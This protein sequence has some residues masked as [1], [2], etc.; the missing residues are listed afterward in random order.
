MYFQ[1][2]ILTLQRYWGDQGCIVLQPHDLMMGA[3]TFHPATVLRTLG[4]GPWNTAFAQPSRRPGDARYGD[5]PIRLGHY[6]QFQVILKP[7]PIDVLD[8]Y[9][10]SLAAIGIDLGAHDVRFVEDDWKSPT[11]GAWGIGWEVWLDGMEVTQFTYFQQVGGLPTMPVPAEITYGLERL[12][13]QLQGKKSVYDM[14]WVKGITYGHVFHRNEVEQSKYNFEHSDPE[15]LFEEFNRNF[16]ECQ[17]LADLGLA[18]PAYDRCIMT[19][20]AFNLLDARGAISVAERANYIDRIRGL[21]CACATVWDREVASHET[22]AVPPPAPVVVPASGTPDGRREL[23]VEVVCEELPATFV[24][25]M[26]DAL[27]AGVVSLLDGIDHGEVRLYATPRRLA[28]S[29]AGVADGRPTVSR[30]I[31]G[32][33]A[34]KAVVDGVPTAVGIG[35]ARGKG[36]DPSALKIVDGPK[37]RV[38]AVAVSEGG[39]RTVDRLAAGLDAVI[40]GIPS[41]KSMEWGCGGT[42]WARPIHRV[43]ALYDGVRIAGVAAGV[44]LGDETIGHRLKPDPFTFRGAHDWVAGLRA[45]WVEPDLDLRKAKIRELLTLAASDLGCDPIDDE[46]LLEEVTHLVEAPTLVIGRFDPELLGLPPRLLVQTM[47]QNQRYFPVFRQGKLSSEFVIVSNNPGGDPT[48]VAEGNA[49]VILARFDDARFF[50]AEDRK[51]RLEEHGRKLRDMRWIRGLGTVADRQARVAEL[52][53]TLA[54]RFGADRAVVARAGELAKCDLVTQMVGE[55]PDLQGHVGMLYARGQGEPDAVAVAIEEAWQPRFADD[56]VAASPAGAALAIADRLDTLVGC[57]GIGLVPKGSGDPQGL[58]R[59]AL[60]LLR[61]VI[62]RGLRVDLRELCRAAIGVFDAEVARAPAGFEAW[63]GARAAKS[64]DALVTELVEFAIARFKAYV[65]TT[66]DV[67][68]AVVA[69]SDP[70][71]LV[72]ARKVEALGGL[73]GHSEFAEIM[74]VFKRVLNITRG[75]AFPSPVASALGTPAERALLDA[76]AAVEGEIASAVGALDFRRALDRMLV[77]RRPVADL[78]DAVMVDAPDPAEKAARIGLLLRVARTFL[79]VAD[80]SRIST[81]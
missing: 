17:R 77:L 10:G 69:A 13:A 39:E 73:T 63:T 57:F 67:V 38:V 55:F 29:V 68:D 50:L 21:A 46:P 80:F 16:A 43:N 30:T 56:A 51:K 65:G 60:G 71:P 66:A 79:A 11:L 40:R 62:D 36:V 42:R 49:A 24:R 3:G 52:A 34:D 41:P 26:L 64:T 44:A 47:K 78:F 7:S 70:D 33:P 37:G 23:F 76:T 19:S 59:A 20:H 22:P 6:Y 12:T 32:P 14:E 74:V 2:V 27:R 61:T 25:P 53:V 5:N 72:L 75:H 9:L 45:R 81:R 28:V 8:K 1:D 4:P 48:T 54:E 15:A 31:T 58:R 18:L 35:F